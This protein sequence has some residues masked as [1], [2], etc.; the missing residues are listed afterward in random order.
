LAPEG[1]T[2]D[3]PPGLPEAKVDELEWTLSRSLAQLESESDSEKLAELR[4]LIAQR[5]SKS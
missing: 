2:A 1:P 4:R 5:R 3:S